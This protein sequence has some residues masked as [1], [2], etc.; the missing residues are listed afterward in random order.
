MQ[1]RSCSVFMLPQPA[2]FSPFH[3]TRRL[4]LS[5]LIAYKTK[6]R[7]AQAFAPGSPD[8]SRKRHRR[9]AAARLL[10]GDS[11]YTLFQWPKSDSGFRPVCV[12]RCSKEI[13][14]R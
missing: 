13:L 6:H 7:K 11:C 8:P 2:R 4:L 5:T 9:R 12:H 1:E 10:R 14:W 3:K